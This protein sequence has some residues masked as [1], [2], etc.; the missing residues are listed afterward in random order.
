MSAL[1]LYRTLILLLPTSPCILS[2]F[3]PIS[4]FVS[5]VLCSSPQSSMLHPH[6][7]TFLSVVHS[8]WLSAPAEKLNSTCLCVWER[9]SEYFLSSE[10]FWAADFLFSD[11]ERQM[12]WHYSFYFF[13]LYLLL[14]PFLLSPLPLDPFLRFPRFRWLKSTLVWI[15]KRHYSPLFSVF[16]LFPESN[17]S[18]APRVYLYF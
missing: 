2:T 8:L 13:L 1:L 9:T 10:L 17:K 5:R 11:D 12:F 6:A 18:F 16:L 15:Q 3:R 7:L 14:L 4:L